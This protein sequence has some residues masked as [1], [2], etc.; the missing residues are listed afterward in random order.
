VLAAACR[1]GAEGIV[2]KRVDQPYA[3]GNRGIW[4]K[5]KCLNRQEF[6]IVG[7]TEGEGSRKELGSL[8]LGYY[9]DGELVYAGRAGTGMTWKEMADL[10]QRLEPLA[11]ERMPLAAP[12]PRDSRFGRPLELRRVYWVRPELVVEVTFLTWTDDGLL[13]QVAYQG[14]RE[15]KDPNKVRLE[16]ASE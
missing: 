13:R 5:T 2:S 10:R 14:L 16:R 3:P 12:P 9:R 8:L 15:D 1:I 6:V 7:W 11:I 4:I